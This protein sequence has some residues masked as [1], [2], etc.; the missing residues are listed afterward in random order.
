MELLSV[1]RR[2]HHREH[3]PIREIERRSGLSRNTI[4][5]YLRSDAVEVRFK[6][7]QRPS[8]LDPFADKLSGWLEAEVTKG[9]K[10]RRTARRLHAD[11]VALG[12]EGSYA[13]V[14][15]FVRHWRAARA[16]AERTT[17]RGV[18]VPLAF[19]PGEGTMRKCVAF[20]P[21]SPDRRWPG[22]RLPAP[23]AT[24][25]TTAGGCRRGHGCGFAAGG[26]RRA[27]STASAGAWQNAC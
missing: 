19:A 12:Y 25:R 9:R 2:W 23:G 7:P 24:A 18:F 20:T 10:V 26:G 16:V 1:I 27:G 13:R 3:L 15:A 17:G 22:C 4:R 6:V 5:K 11:L 8:R 21:R 14:A